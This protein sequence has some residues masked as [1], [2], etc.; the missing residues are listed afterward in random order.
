MSENL[1]QTDVHE[2]LDVGT[3]ARTRVATVLRSKRSAAAAAAVVGSVLVAVPLIGAT[4]IPGG[5]S[6]PDVK[7]VA[8][9]HQIAFKPDPTGVGNDM[10]PTPPKPAPAKPAPAKPKA[11]ASSEDR[12]SRSESRTAIPS[13][14]KTSGS[15]KA[16]A[17]SMLAERGWSGQFSC[18]NSLWEKE[19]NWNP[20]AY[21]A[22][23]GATGIPQA[24]PGSKMASAGSDWRTN[25]ATQIEWGLDYISETYGTPCAAWSHSQAN[26]WY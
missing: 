21:N 18:L 10:L 5:A 26:N 23:S 15:P 1:R 24:L 3:S 19:S 13:K 14:G 22:S 4:S 12:A 7:P 6:E 2:S 16:I 25:P 17:Q 9:E 20:G 8:A 11:T